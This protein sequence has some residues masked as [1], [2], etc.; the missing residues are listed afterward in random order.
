MVEAKG[1]QGA[2]SWGKNMAEAKKMIA[3]SIEG[4]IE[5]HIILEAERQGVSVFEDFLKL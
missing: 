2:L 5:A 3:E 1:L 4:S